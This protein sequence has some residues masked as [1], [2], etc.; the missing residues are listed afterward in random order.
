M[1]SGICAG[2]VIYLL[3]YLFYLIIYL[4]IFETKRKIF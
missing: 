4:S 3:G 2:V 1:V